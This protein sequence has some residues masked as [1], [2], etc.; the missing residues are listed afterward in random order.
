MKQYFKKI[1]ATAYIE[2]CAVSPGYSQ[3]LVNIQAGRH[4]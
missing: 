3:D 2:L 1:A 4:S